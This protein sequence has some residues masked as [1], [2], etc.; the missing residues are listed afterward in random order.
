MNIRAVRADGC[1]SDWR[2][3]HGLRWRLY[4]NTLNDLALHS[5]YAIALHPKNL[6]LWLIDQVARAA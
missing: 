5:F 4:A 6:S 2:I 1:H 3:P